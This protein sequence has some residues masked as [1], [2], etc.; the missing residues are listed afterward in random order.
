MFDLLIDCIVFI[1]VCFLVNLFNLMIRKTCNNSR[2]FE[3]I[4]RISNM[5]K[6][7]W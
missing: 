1:V 7:W 2:R 4:Y 5:G 3:S 6:Y